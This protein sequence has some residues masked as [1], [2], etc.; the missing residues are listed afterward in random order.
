[1]TGEMGRYTVL[2]WENTAQVSLPQGCAIVAFRQGPACLGSHW[3]R[4]KCSWTGAVWRSCTFILL[5]VETVCCFAM[6]FKWSWVRDKSMFVAQQGRNLGRSHRGI[7]F[8][9][10]E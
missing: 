8:D 1:M 4:H 2:R 10:A 5:D 7:Q 9:S 6:K 3:V